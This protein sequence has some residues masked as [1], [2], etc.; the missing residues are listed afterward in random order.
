MGGGRNITTV[1]EESGMDCRFL[2]AFRQGKLE[3]NS[4]HLEKG[5]ESAGS[6]MENSNDLPG[7]SSFIYIME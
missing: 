6:Q 2:T 7:H 1:T 3:E 5:C 4:S